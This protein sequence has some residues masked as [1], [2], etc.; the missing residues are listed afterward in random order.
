M[1]KTTILKYSHHS[2]ILT[3]SNK[4]TIIITTAILILTTLSAG[5]TDTVGTYLKIETIAN[6]YFKSV[7]EYIKKIVLDSI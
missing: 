4:T 2:S 6:E 7:G 5:C 1:M 3:Q